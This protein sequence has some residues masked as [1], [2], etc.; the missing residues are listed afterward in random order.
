MHALVVV[1][2]NVNAPFNALAYRAK[3][4]GFRAAFTVYARAD[5]LALQAHPSAAFQRRRDSITG[6]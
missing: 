6:S 4:R 1:A 5:P 3:A 2:S